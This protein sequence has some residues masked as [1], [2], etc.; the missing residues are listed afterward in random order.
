MLGRE[1]DNAL[2]VKGKRVLIKDYCMI[3]LIC[4]HSDS[5]S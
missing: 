1:A 4:L 5:S 2:Y 3:L